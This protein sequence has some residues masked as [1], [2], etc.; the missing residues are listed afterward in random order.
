MPLLAGVVYTADT[1]LVKADLLRELG[2]V[3]LAEVYFEK[4]LG[5]YDDKVLEPDIKYHFGDGFSIHTETGVVAAQ[6]A[7]AAKVPAVK[8]LAA[9]R[10]IWVEGV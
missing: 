7:Y 4:E 8:D 9:V 2:V 3:R 6:Y 10:E 5:V 1:G